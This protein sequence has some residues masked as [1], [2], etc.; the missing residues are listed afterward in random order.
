MIKRLVL[1]HTVTKWK[2]QN[3]NPLLLDS[4]TQALPHH[5]SQLPVPLL[6]SPALCSGFIQECR[7]PFPVTPRRGGHHATRFTEEGH[8]AQRGQVTQLGRG[9]VRTQTQVQLWGQC[10]YSMLLSSPYE[11]TENW[12]FLAYEI[13]NVT[14]TNGKK[15][16]LPKPSEVY[17]ASIH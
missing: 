15:Y 3:L 7:G 9:K 2:T 17:G 10:S 12:L 13:Y 16:T 14:C 5:A 1:G 8:K 11:I 4:R 6:P